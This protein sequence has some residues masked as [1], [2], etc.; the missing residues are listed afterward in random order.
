MGNV[1]ASDCGKDSSGRNLAKDM[2]KSSGSNSTSSFGF[3]LHCPVNS[4]KLGAGNGSLGAAGRVLPPPTPNR[5]CPSSPFPPMGAGGGGGPIALL[6]SGQRGDEAT[7]SW[8]ETVLAL[9][10]YRRRPPP[11]PPPCPPEPR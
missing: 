4:V 11:P 2:K 9:P 3:W 8:C 10:P 7:L 5:T 6:D 1:G